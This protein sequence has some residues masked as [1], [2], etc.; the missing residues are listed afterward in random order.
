LLRNTGPIRFVGAVAD[1]DALLL[2]SDKATREVI[3]AA[4]MK[5]IVR[6]G[7]GYEIL[8]GIRHRKGVVG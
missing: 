6:A 3:E 1:A 4:K 7:A 8:L 2:R 5:I